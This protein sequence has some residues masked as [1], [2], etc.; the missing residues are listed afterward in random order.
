MHHIIFRLYLY[1]LNILYFSKY[2]CT[3][4]F[5]RRS[6]YTSNRKYKWFSLCNIFKY[7]QF[8]PTLSSKLCYIYL[9]Q[10]IFV[11]QVPDRHACSLDSAHYAH[12]ECYVHG[13]CMRR[14]WPPP[15]LHFHQVWMWHTNTDA[16]WY[17]CPNQPLWHSCV[18]QKLFWESSSRLKYT[19]N[20]KTVH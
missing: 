10:S 16:A 18:Y 9:L 6:L 1:F 8:G 7:M 14:I 4:I 5:H 2:S 17:L 3:N 11:H 15:Y 13:W 12:G 19:R 20:C